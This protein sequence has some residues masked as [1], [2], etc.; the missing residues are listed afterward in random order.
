MPDA[1]GA[2]HVTSVG[3][4][5]YVCGFVNGAASKSDKK[6]GV[7]GLTMFDLRRRGLIG[8]QFSIVGTNGDK[9]PEI[10]QFMKTNIEQRYRDMSTAFEAYP[11]VGVRDPE[12]YKA[13]IDALSPG[14]AITIFT[15]DTTHFPIAVYAM[16]KKIHVLV[17]KPATKVLADHMELARIARE[18]GVMCFVEHHKRFDPAYSDGREKAREELGDL[19]CA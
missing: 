15:P 14:D 17:T 16:R 12:A 5:E 1:K 9:F 2:P 18:E 8:S 11:A 4:G 19:S 13:A 10:R 7:V 3:S 6:I